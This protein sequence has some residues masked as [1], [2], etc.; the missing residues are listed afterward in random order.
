MLE[1]KLSDIAQSVMQQFKLFKIRLE[2]QSGNIFR[3]S[4]AVC[5]TKCDAFREIM[6]HYDAFV[7]Q[8]FQLSGLFNWLPAGF[9]WLRRPRVR[10]IFLEVFDDL[11]FSFIVKLMEKLQT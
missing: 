2:R 10:L 8:M 7:M 9:M 5:V 6:R 1:M 11:N 4:T 3:I